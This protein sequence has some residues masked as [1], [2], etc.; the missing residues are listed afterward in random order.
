M[1][2][3]PALQARQKAAQLPA[4]ALVAPTVAQTRWAE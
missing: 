3:R 1:F 4:P 2:C